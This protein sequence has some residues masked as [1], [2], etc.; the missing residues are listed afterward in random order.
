MTVRDGGD[1]ISELVEEEVC[2]MIEDWRTLVMSCSWGVLVV[3]VQDCPDHPALL[4]TPEERV[5]K[6][7]AAGA[8]AIVIDILAYVILKKRS[9]GV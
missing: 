8:G 2:M 5:R 4:V 9:A 1:G 3:G 6:V 7:I